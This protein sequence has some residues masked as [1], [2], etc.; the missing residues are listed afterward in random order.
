M[1]ITNVE[2]TV[3]TVSVDLPLLEKPPDTSGYPFDVT[4][5]IATVETDAGITGY[6]ETGYLNPMATADFIN[7]EIAPEVTG[8]DPR[9][10]THVWEQ[11]NTK[12]NPRAQTGTWSTAVSAV[13]I[14]LW[15][16]KGKAF[17]EPVWRLLGGMNEQVPAYITFG[18]AEYTIDQLSSVANRLVSE[19][20]T[21][22]KMK[23]GWD[24]NVTPYQDA[25]RV[26]AVREA[27][28]DQVELFIDANYQY[29][30]REALELCNRVESENIGWFEEP[31]Y[32]NDAKLL[33]SLRSRTRIPI[34]AGQNEG[35]S[36]RHRE[37]IT[38]DS[39]DVSQPNVCFVGGYT[40]G[41]RVA[42][43]ARTHNL[44]IANG[45]GW[46][47]HNMHLQA[48][49]SNGSL[50]EFHYAHW[51]ANKL[52]YESLPEPTNGVLTLPDSPG[53]GLKPDRDVLAK[54]RVG[55]EE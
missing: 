18:L 31:V 54:T 44:R 21:R 12:L 49:V 29:S 30:I 41:K 15:D 52:L 26:S 2:A 37:L 20:Q 13:D 27:V 24:D 39:V 47:F 45:G 22:L 42:H 5:A 11:L 32:G 38:N 43:V 8:M 14:A 53:V 6:G 48:G 36:F 28:G 3:H 19:G 35:H 10:T 34:A 9:R 16:I 17:D 40:E 1:E 50:V 4:V 33:S 51:E 25:E 55:T 7:N 46:P 23:V